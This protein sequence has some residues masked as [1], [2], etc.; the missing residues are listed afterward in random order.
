[1]ANYKDKDL[2]EKYVSEQHLSHRV[3]YCADGYYRAVDVLDMVICRSRTHVQCGQQNMQ[4]T[5]GLMQHV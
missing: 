4:I 3:K 5:T 1:M 2:E